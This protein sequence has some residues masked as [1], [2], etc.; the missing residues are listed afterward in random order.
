M[1]IGMSSSMEVATT[2]LTL[3]VGTRVGPKLVG[4]L[5]FGGEARVFPLNRE[6]EDNG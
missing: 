2:S 4:I 3:L 6:E 1:T 5:E